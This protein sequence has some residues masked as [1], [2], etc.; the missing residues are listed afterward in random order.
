MIYLQGY[1][2]KKSA[3][4]K[5]AHKD[6]PPLYRGE[7]WSVLLGVMGDIDAEYRMIDK[8]T[9]TVTDRQVSINLHQGCS[10]AR[11]VPTLVKKKKIIIVFL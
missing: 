7:I 9:I 11:T 3:I 2:F 10:G 4:V 5:E 8:E 6:I 1:P